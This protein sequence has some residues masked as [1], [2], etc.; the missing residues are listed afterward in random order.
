MSAI[1]R[2]GLGGPKRAYGAFTPKEL[3]PFCLVSNY[4]EIRFDPATGLVSAGFLIELY[5]SDG[6]R[7]PL[8]NPDSAS[9]LFDSAQAWS[10]TRA[11]IIDTIVARALEFGVS[12]NPHN[13][14]FRLPEI[15]RG[16]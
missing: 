3:P 4:R 13:I 15:E 6:T 16:S 8:D 5:V 7:L 2:R 14:I 1:T 12:L 9:V 11:Q 10:V